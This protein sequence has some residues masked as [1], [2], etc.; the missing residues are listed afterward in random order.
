[1]KVTNPYTSAEQLLKLIL[2]GASTRHFNRPLAGRSDTDDHSLAHKHRA[3]DCRLLDSNF[4]VDDCQGPYTLPVYT[5]HE[6][7]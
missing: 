6:H 3:L 4:I 7:R 2:V 5:A 1:L